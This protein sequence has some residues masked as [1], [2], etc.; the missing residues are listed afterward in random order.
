MLYPESL[1]GSGSSYQ[2]SAS[3]PLHNV[4]TG[5]Y[6]APTADECEAIRDFLPASTPTDGVSDAART[7]L[8]ARAPD[9]YF[10]AGYLAAMRVLTED[11]KPARLAVAAAQRQPRVPRGVAAEKKER[12]I[13]AR[14]QACVKGALSQ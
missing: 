11:A 2:P 1:G 14:L 8:I 12:K 13:Y 4:V 7:T 5:M 9:V 10:L 3:H 6:E